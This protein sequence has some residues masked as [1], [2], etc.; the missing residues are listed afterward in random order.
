M[1]ELPH[2]QAIRRMTKTLQGFAKVTAVYLFGSITVG[3]FREGW[4][5]IDM[6]CLTK[7]PLSEQAAE[8]LLMLRQRMVEETGDPVYRSFEGGIV[9]LEALRDG[10]PAL[11]VYWGTSGQRV[12]NTF[13]MDCFSRWQ[14]AHHG[15]LQ[16]GQD[17]RRQLGDPTRPQLFAGVREHYHAIRSIPQG[18]G[19]SL[20]S[21]GLLLD[22]SRGLY[23]LRTGR[24]AAKTTA[25]EWA[26]E[27]RLC[28]VAEDLQAA[29]SLRYDPSLF[30]QEKQLWAEK[31]GPSIQRYADVLA[32]ELEVHK[33]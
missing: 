22:I 19:C 9:P 20:Y 2:A 4:S 32:R 7:E 13:T 6:L 24:V 29:V 25:G 30:T 14:L 31:L 8:R 28:P 21:P 16:A 26:L 15:I 12:T 17:V 33:A 23:T 11:S 3:D 10:K 27:N 1:L 5:D 18:A